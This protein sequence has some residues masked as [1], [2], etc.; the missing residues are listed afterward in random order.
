MNRISAPVP[1]FS[2][3]MKTPKFMHTISS[4]CCM[5]C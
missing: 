4:K 3:R 1:V 5:C 2:F